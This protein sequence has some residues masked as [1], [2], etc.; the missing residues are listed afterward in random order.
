MAL[1]ML[2]I[3]LKLTDLPQG[4]SASLVL[5]SFALEKLDWCHLPWLTTFAMQ[6]LPEAPRP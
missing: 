3:N 5:L 4:L 1:L 6:C 2:I